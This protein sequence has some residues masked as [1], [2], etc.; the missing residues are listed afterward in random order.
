LKLIP[1]DVGRLITDLQ[2]DIQI[3]DLEM[4]IR[5]VIDFLITKEIEVQ[6][7]AGRWH[8]LVLRPY[9]TVDNK[10]SGAVLVLFDIEES[11]RNIRQKQQAADFADALLETVRSASL[12]LDLNLRIKRAAPAFYRLFR[13]EPEKTEG[14][15]FYEIGEGEWDTPELRLLLEDVLPKN[16]RVS[17][18]EVWQ[19]VP[20]VGRRKLA[21][22]AYR[23]AAS[24]DNEHF[25]IVSIEEVT[26]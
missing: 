26:P 5:Q 2:P 8:S 17:D 10:I 14:R 11:K 7:T 4:Q 16:S 22:N 3:P 20:K 9:E 25:I 12:L 23:T 6:D 1:S 19:T 18:F 21:L 15:L 13:T 24:V